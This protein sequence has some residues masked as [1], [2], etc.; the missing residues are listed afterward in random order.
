MK[1]TKNSGL[2]KNMGISGAYWDIHKRTGA[3]LI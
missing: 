3:E 1:F 2:V